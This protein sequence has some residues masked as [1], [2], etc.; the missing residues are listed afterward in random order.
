MSEKQET[1]ADVSAWARGLVKPGETLNNTY[2]LLNGLA[3]RYDAAHKRDIEAYDF[4]NFMSPVG[5]AKPAPV[6]NGA[7]MREALVLA[8]SLLD[9]KEGVPYKTVSQ[10]DLDFMKDALAEPPRNCDAISED[11]MKERYREAL[12]EEVEKGLPIAEELKALIVEVVTDTITSLYATYKEDGA[13][14]EEG[15]EG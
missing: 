3:D 12:E 13:E 9:L 2:E 14:Q 11:V 15:G 7:K 6:G 8:L 1:V 5:R 10:K 4:I